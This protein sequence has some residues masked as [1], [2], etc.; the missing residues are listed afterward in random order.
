MEI[1]RPT[2]MEV[3]LNAFE[4]NVK[5]IRKYIGKTVDIMPVIKGNAYGTEIN[6]RNDIIEKFDIVAVALIDEA[7][8]LR[9]NSFSKEIFVLNQPYISEIQKIINYNITI[10]LSDESFLDEIGKLEDVIKVHIEIESGMGRT[11]VAPNKLDEFMA[12]IKNYP[13]IKVEGI[14]THLSSADSDEAYTKKQLEIFDNAVNKAKSVFGDIKYIHCSASNGTLNYPSNSYNLIRPGMIL[15]GY[16]SC[17]NAKQKIDLRPVCKLKSKITFLKEV[18][19]GTS[20]GY[21]RHFISKKKT[22]V[23]T[24]P[25][26][27]ADG[28]KRAL[29]NGGEVVINGKRV[30]IIGKICMDSFM[31]DVTELEDVN[32]G[33]DV[34]IWDN[35]NV[36]VEEIA[37]KTNTINYEIISTIS[38]RVPRFFYDNM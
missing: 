32:V 27:Y 10:G 19:E 1:T 4:H 23:A 25:I 28:L 9:K 38:I 14:Y 2:R 5:E 12:K 15:Y 8:D 33:D 35:K 13:N 7:V 18:E 22:K 11:G 17:N 24:I 37:N 29:S 20:I 36:T 31:A 16:E 34:Y 3:D 30:P 6:Y 21:S 26:G